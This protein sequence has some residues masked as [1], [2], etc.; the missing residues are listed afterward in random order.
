MRFIEIERSVQ[1]NNWNMKDLHSH[2]HYEIYYLYKGSRTFL[3]SNALYLLEA[4]VLVIIPPYTMH[5]TEGGP[6]ERYNI[7]VS[8]EY[9]NEFQREVL[10]EKALQRILPNTEHGQK[11]LE[12]LSD[13]SAIDKR[14]KRGEHEINALFSYFVYLL[15]KMNADESRIT[16]PEDNKMSPLVLRIINYFNEHYA[17]NISL[18]VLSREFFASKTTLIYNFKK[19]TNCSPID[20]LLSV[21]L[22]KA[23][24]QLV[25]TK[26]GIEDI[27][28]SCG[29][30]S[31]NYFGLIFKKKEGLSPSSYRK[32]QLS[33]S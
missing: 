9:L 28:L 24:E 22:T 26:K 5:K 6:F 15:S 32:Y 4:P 20:F 13:L 30:S 11:L 25:N 8:P 7:D 10:D 16:S 12:L 18:E 31:A 14:Q 33:K 29:F 23:K 21:R 27:A 17:E 1:K 2:S 19:Y 3:L